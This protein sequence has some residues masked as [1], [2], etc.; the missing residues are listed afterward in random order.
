M[1]WPTVQG[2]VISSDWIR[3]G[4]QGNTEPE[5]KYE[6]DV[7]GQ[8]YKSDKI[9]FHGLE[10]DSVV[11][12]YK[13]GREAKIYYDP[14]DPQTSVLL[15]G[16]KTQSAMLMLLIAAGCAVFGWGGLFFIIKDK[17]KSQRV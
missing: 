9:S 1:N 16:Y 15:P 17:R 7:D 13:E 3:T 12:N 6:Y 10:E 2:T 5:I 14:Q 11:Y 8:H 4:T